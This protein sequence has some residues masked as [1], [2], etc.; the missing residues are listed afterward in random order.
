[1]D[2]EPRHT[3]AE[4]IAIARPARG[5]QILAAVRETGGTIVTV[6]DQVR[7]AHTALAR[8]G[9]YVEPTSA[10]CWAVDAVYADFFTEPRLARSCFA[11]EVVGK[12]K[13]VSRGCRR[14]RSMALIVDPGGTRDRQCH[15]A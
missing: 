8:A 10:V 3:I 4:G 7:V 6:T 5:A 13:T 2:V 15:R 9:L 11:A 14:A 1:V 12:N